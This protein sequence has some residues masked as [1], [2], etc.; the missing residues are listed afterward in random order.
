MELEHTVQSS[1]DDLLQGNMFIKQLL[2][3][4]GW[5]QKYTSKNN[6]VLQPMTSH[7]PSYG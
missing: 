7:L 1:L 6:S 2:K 4:I 5:L 3:Q